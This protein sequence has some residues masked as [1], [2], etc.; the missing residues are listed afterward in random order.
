MI[1]L[2]YRPTTLPV[3]LDIIKIAIAVYFLNLEVV[4][5]GLMV[6]L[7]VIPTGIIMSLMM[8]VLKIG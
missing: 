5:S 6:S 7:L 1:L 2:I 8:L 3:G 4:G